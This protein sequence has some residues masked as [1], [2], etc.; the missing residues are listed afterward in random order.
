MKDVQ[1]YEGLYA[2]TSCGKVYS[3]RSKKF[4]KPRK[5]KSGYLQVCLYKGGERKEHLVHRLVAE[6]YL[7]NPEE[8]L[9]VNH[10][11]ENKENNALSNLEWCDQS[12]NSNY[13]S[14]NKRM[15]K[16]LSKPVFCEELNRTFDGARAAACELG[17]DYSSINRCCTGK[18]KTCGGYHW[19]YQEVT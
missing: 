1:N 11:D 4:L 9:Q 6:A 15:A 3:Y 19:R 13:G 8:F 10:K 12:Y 18:R 14:R 5:N 7:P 2:V 16:S 17:L